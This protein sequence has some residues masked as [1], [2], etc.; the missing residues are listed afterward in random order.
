MEEMLFKNDGRTEKILAIEYFRDDSGKILPFSV[1]TAGSDNPDYHS[2][3]D[4]DFCKSNQTLYY[5]NSSMGCAFYVNK[6]ANPSI[7]PSSF[8]WWDKSIHPESNDGQ[9]RRHLTVEEIKAIGY[10]VI[11][12]PLE[13]DGSKNPFDNAE[14]GELQYCSEC[15]EFFREDDL[16][17]HIWW[18]DKCGWFSTPD[19]RCGHKQ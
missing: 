7:P 6:L 15:D 17:E 19:E 14:Y 5:H 13:I 11:G 18:C 3:Y 2:E 8:L 1:F 4:F 9:A 10:G 12:E 16:C